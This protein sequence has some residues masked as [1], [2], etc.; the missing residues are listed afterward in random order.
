MSVT[1]FA[2]MFVVGGNLQG[3]FTAELVPGPA[4]AQSTATRINSPLSRVLKSVSTGS[5]ILP[6][7]LSGEANELLWVMNDS[8]NTINVYPAS[9]EKTNGPL[10]TAFQIT[11]GL[12]GVFVP[13]LNSVNNYP[14]TLD[15][16]SAVIP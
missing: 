14:S 11:T 2:V 15:W 16:R 5:L 6:S 3:S 9:G 4:A 10:N 8:P 12:T 1:N 13:V 7:I